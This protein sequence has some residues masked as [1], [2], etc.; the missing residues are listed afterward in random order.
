MKKKGGTVV[1]L[2]GLGQHLV[3]GATV[4]MVRRGMRQAI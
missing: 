1:H 4:E 2:S 3:Y